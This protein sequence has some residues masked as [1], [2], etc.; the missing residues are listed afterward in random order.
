MTADQDTVTDKPFPWMR[1]R[2]I[3]AR[4]PEYL[5]APRAL[6]ADH[7]IVCDRDD[8]INGKFVGGLCNGTPTAYGSESCI[9]EVRASVGGWVICNDRGQYLRTSGAW[10]GDERRIRRFKTPLAAAVAAEAEDGSGRV[11]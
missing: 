11:L 9:H 7:W 6:L 4:P 5:D 10:S 3:A 8:Y 2:R 1:N